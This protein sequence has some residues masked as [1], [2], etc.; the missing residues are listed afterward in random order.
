MKLQCQECCVL[1]MQRN[2]TVN[3]DSL[4]SYTEDT[5]STSEAKVS[6]INAISRSAS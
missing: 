2:K 3:L 6:R 5:V 4:H 1:E